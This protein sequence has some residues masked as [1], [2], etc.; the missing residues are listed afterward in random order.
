ML[1]DSKTRRL[2]PE[3]LDDDKTALDA[4]KTLTSYSPSNAEISL[5]SLEAAYEAMTGNQTGETQAK[6]AY[7][8]KRDTTVKSEHGFHDLMIRAYDAVK[9]QY[10]RDSAEVQAMGRKRVSEY[11]R[12][13]R[14]KPTGNV[15][16]TGGES[17]AGG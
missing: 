10:G 1:R 5:A 6:I 17:S 8:A 12:P 15:S 11:K 13:T 9:G 7:E 4:L 16:A 3:L 14:K 2:R